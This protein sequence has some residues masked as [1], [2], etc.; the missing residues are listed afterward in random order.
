MSSYHA[1]LCL[2]AGAGWAYEGLQLLSDLLILLQDLG[3]LLHKV[4]GFSRIWQIP[5]LQHRDQVHNAARLE[6]RDREHLSSEMDWIHTGDNHDLREHCLVVGVRLKHT[7]TKT[8][9]NLT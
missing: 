8:H 5:C 3:Q 4:L 9:Q 1:A 2:F 6:T 7:D